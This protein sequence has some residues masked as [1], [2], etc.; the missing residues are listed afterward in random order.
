MKKQKTQ[1]VRIKMVNEILSGMKVLK[2]YGWELSFMDL[3]NKIRKTELKQLRRQSLLSIVTTFLWG[4]SPLLITIISFG[5]FI[6]LNESEKFTVNVA[7]VS[8]SLF[9]ILRFPLSILPGIIAALINAN[10]SLK[11]IETHLL[12][13]EINESDISYEPMADVAIRASGASFGWDAQKQ[14]LNELNF[15]VGKGK[16][17]AIVG[18]VGAGKSTLLS[19]ILGEM[20]KLNE[21]I[22][23][24]SG[25][26][27][28]V[29]QQAWIQNLTVKNNILFGHKHDAKLYDRVVDACSLRAD[30]Q[31][32]PAGD[33]TEIG[34]KGINLSGG[35][36]QRISLARSVY[37]SANI[38]LLDDP[39]SAVDSHVGKSIFDQ[40]IGPNGLLKDKTRLFVTNSL[41]F[42]PQTDEIFMLE[43]GRIVEMG[44]YEQLLA[45]GGHFSE[46]IRNFLSNNEA[47]NDEE[48]PDAS[49]SNLE[50]KRNEILSQSKAESV[51]KLNTSAVSLNKSVRRHSSTKAKETPE[52]NQHKGETIIRKEKIESGKVSFISIEFFLKNASSDFCYKF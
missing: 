36:K 27:A 43:S 5:T 12:R 6:L 1:D 52:S 33:N 47:S 51:S 10:V 18:Q 37:A 24:V 30:L 11:R 22:V 50:D 46:F 3:V 45:R 2:F 34:E 40:V 35:Q 49:A 31:I 7:F 20:H 14:F 8:I 29:P 13:D 25:S 48:E 44:S 15:D 4:C 26:C 41:S 32:M 23:N 17:V 39:L 38:Y 9:N 42:L 16:L 21:G 28:Y 19:A